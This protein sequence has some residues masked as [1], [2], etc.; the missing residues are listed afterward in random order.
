M[1]S[2]AACSSPTETT[3]GSRGRWI[4]QR[5]CHRCDFTGPETEFLAGGVV[6]GAVV[7]VPLDE[8]WGDFRPYCIGCAV[9]M[10]NEH[11]QSLS[12]AVRHLMGEHS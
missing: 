1:S 10:G 8:G 3:S 9:Q 5:S 2:S 7:F 4:G 11:P 6:E 12:E